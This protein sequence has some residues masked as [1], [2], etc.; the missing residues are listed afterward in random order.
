MQTMSGLFLE[1]RVQQLERRLRLFQI[2]FVIGIVSF[3][4]V[5]FSRIT[6]SQVLGTPAY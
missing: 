1:R 4:V 6:S 5:T 3:S 2:G